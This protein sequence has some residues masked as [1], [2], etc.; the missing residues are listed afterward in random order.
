M[1]EMSL[2]CVILVI[3]TAQIWVFQ[4]IDVVG[5]VAVAWF[6]FLA[7]KLYMTEEIFILYK[8]PNMLL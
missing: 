4:N 5:S 7:Q 1:G 3:Q 6:I 2:N 8:Q